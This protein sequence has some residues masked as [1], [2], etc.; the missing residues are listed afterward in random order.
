M[1]QKPILSIVIMAILVSPLWAQVESDFQ[2][3][4]NR[5]N[6]LTITGYTGSARDVVI[7]GTLYGLRV[8]AIGYQAFHRKNLTSVVIPNTVRT[9]GSMAFT[10]N[11]NITEISIPDSVIE[12]GDGAFAGDFHQRGRLNRVHIGRGIQNIATNAFRYNSITELNLPTSIRTIGERA[13][14]GNRITSLSIPNGVTLIEGL[15]FENNPLET[16]VIPSS[17]AG[18]FRET[19]GIMGRR[20]VMVTGI[21]S[22]AFS[23]TR[24]TRITFPANFR[25][26]G[27]DETNPYL[28]SGFEESLIN[29]YINQNRAAGTYVK[30]GP[31]W[32]RE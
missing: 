12:I 2:V 6:T 10:Y 7:P 8:T 25:N 19:T 27:S 32:T 15:A 22:S 29:F 17:L 18:T 26:H 14:S 3:V 21:Y 28:V 5:D 9:I 4:Q 16:L 13:F 1:K 20:V 24:L 31:I 11:H 30:R 23:N